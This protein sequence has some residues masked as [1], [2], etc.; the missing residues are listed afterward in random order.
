MI[1]VSLL[2]VC[3]GMAIVLQSGC[4]D[5]MEYKKDMRRDFVNPGSYGYREVFPKEWL[6]KGKT[7]PFEDTTVLLPERYD[8]YLRHFFGDY[9]QLPPVEQRIEK[10]NRSYLNMN[11]REPIEEVKKKLG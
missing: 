1:T 3:K 2:F 10:H 6:G 11:A 8:E 7:F 9:M 4:K 5:D